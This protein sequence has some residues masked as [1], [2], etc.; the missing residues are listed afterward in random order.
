MN[1]LG[2]E[3]IPYLTQVSMVAPKIIQSL[4]Y[5]GCSV[6]VKAVNIMIP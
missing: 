1:S 6:S 2:A 5:S 4:V 3:T